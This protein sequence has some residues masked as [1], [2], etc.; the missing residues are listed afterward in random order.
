MV[1]LLGVPTT[2]GRGQHSE[3]VLCPGLWTTEAVPTTLRNARG[4]DLKAFDEIVNGQFA[5]LR[6]DQLVGLGMTPRQIE[7]RLT[8]GRWTALHRAVY[9][10]EPGR[11]DAEMLSLAAVFACGEGAV[12]SHRSAA[13]A[14]GLRK[15]APPLF[16]VLIP[17]ARRIAPPAGVRVRRSR[18]ALARTDEHAWP[19]TTSV[20]NTV[21]DVAAEGTADDAVT[22]AA[23]ACQK[24]LTWDEG[25]I[26]ALEQRPRHRWKLLLQ[27]A[28]QDIGDGAQSTFEVR[29]VRDVERAH[30]LPRGRPQQ[31]TGGGRRHH[32]Y[33]YEEQKVL[34]ELDGL[35]F[36][37]APAAR[38]SDG[39]RDRGALAE[40]WATLRAFWPDVGVA[41]CALAVEVAGLLRSKG[42]AGKPRP[43]RRMECAVS[44]EG[45]VES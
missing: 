24:G 16:E 35:S 5:V 2:A 26:R 22:I 1:A 28:L 8:S 25:L 21:L 45:N 11:H 13:F 40:G 44:Q 42:W 4:M 29:Y 33:G 6:R 32:D 38:I 20:E 30:G 37:S 15:A 10:T 17:A 43:C 14:L 39:R 41:P 9:L 7:W 12:L 3:H 18:M 31:P 36:H 34:V 23:L 19:P 27:E